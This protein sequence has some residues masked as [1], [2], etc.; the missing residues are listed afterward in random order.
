M[1]ELGARGGDSL[2]ILRH[3][4]GCALAV[5][6]RHILGRTP[7]VVPWR[8]L[9]HIRAAITQMILRHIPRYEG[10]GYRW[11]LVE[12]QRL[13]GVAFGVEGSHMFV[14]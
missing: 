1:S 14:G 5:I 9:G 4:L 13:D 10:P 11:V 6:V 7:A 8:I 12:A 2:G 3:F